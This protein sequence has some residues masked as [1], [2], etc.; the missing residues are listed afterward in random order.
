MIP[1]Q[2]E[3]ITTPYRVRDL[4][5]DFGGQSVQSMG[6][7]SLPSRYESILHTH[8]KPRPFVTHS[9]PIFFY[10]YYHTAHVIVI[11][12]VSEILVLQSHCTRNSNTHSFRFVLLLSHCTGISNTHG[13]R[14]FWVTIAPNT[15]IPYI[16]H[17]LEK[18][19][20]CIFFFFYNFVCII[21]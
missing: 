12:T 11:H 7:F 4:S 17:N 21:L 9:F 5:S 14:Y 18:K 3:I 13:Y 10:Y 1:N 2:S 8:A 15:R 19:K 16:T 6:V 20:L